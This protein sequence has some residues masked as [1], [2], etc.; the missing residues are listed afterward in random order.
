M[1]PKQHNPHNTSG[2]DAKPQPTN[3]ERQAMKSIN[4]YYQWNCSE[5]P[6]AYLCI[7]SGNLN[8]KSAVR[9]EDQIPNYTCVSQLSLEV[10]KGI[11]TKLQ[12]SLTPIVG[13]KICKVN[14]H[15]HKEE[16]INQQIEYRVSYFLTGEKPG[17]ALLCCSKA[18]MEEMYNFE[19]DNAHPRNLVLEDDFTIDFKRHG[20]YSLEGEKL[21]RDTLC[22]THLKHLCGGKAL[23]ISTSIHLIMH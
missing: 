13:A 1:P 12:P 17:S 15:V 3:A 6:A 10:I 14:R 16:K 23:S 22:F 11:C 2:L 20:I 7:I 19:R 5:A 18:L 4:D 8:A 21:E 9:G